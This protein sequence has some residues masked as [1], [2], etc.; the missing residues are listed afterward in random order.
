M[1]AIACGWEWRWLFG[2]HNLNKAVTP[3]G[4]VT[5]SASPQAKIPTFQWVFCESTLAL[6][7]D[8]PSST[9]VSY[10]SVCDQDIQVFRNIFVTNEW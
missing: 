9:G 1:K 8:L 2:L 7:S 3:A 10:D 6:C 5:D 4:F